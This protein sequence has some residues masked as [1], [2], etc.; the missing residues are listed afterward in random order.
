MPADD[1]DDEYDKILADYAAGHPV[2][3]IEERYGVSRAEIEW[4]VAEDARHHPTSAAAPPRP[5]PPTTVPAPVLIAAALLA[6]GALA[7]L[8]VAVI[9]I[10]AGAW[11]FAPCLALGIA[12][13]ASAAHGLWRGWRGAQVVTIVLGVMLVLS[14][15]PA[16]G[17]NLVAFPSMVVGAALASLVLVPAP[18]RAW[19]A[20]P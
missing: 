20:R 6:L 9:V 8:A 10:V 17:T 1:D 11:L 2:E 18:S 19:F 5:A 13:A 7:Q 15:L 16:L 4:L 3:D 12:I 14:G